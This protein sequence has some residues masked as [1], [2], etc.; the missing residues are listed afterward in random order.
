MFMGYRAVIMRWRMIT[1]SIYLFTYL[2]IIL[3]EWAS[4]ESVIQQTL[5]HTAL[6][7]KVTIYEHIIRRMLQIKN[8]IQSL[9]YFT[10]VMCQINFAYIYWDLAM[11]SLRSTVDENKPQ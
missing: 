8:V 3:M 4:G 6:T 1:L 5:L 11:D 7:E 2:I 9:A 10:G